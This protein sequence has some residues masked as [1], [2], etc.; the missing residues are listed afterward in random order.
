MQCATLAVSFDKGI[1]YSDSLATYAVAFFK[2]SRSF[3]IRR[4]S[5]RRRRFSAVR[6]SCVSRSLLGTLKRLSQLHSVLNGVA[7][8]NDLSGCLL[9]KVFSKF[10]TLIHT[11]SDGSFLPCGVSAVIGAIQLILSLCCFGL[12]YRC[13]NRDVVTEGHSG[14]YLGWV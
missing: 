1:L 5:A 3:I 14:G 2:K 12:F 4:N 7:T 13:C 8:F 11:S 9:L 6:S 10:T